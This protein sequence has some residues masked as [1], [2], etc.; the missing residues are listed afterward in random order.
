MYQLVHILSMALCVLFNTFYGNKLGLSKAKS[1]LSTTVS[2]MFLYVLMLVLAWV[3]NGFKNFGQQNMVRTYAFAPL[4]FLLIMVIFKIDFRKVSDMHAVWPMIM[5]GV[6]HFAC[7][8]EGCCGGFTYRDGTAV[9]DVANALTGTN[10]LPQQALESIAALII[11][12]VI[13]FIAWKKKFNLNGRLFYVMIIV[14]GVNRFFWE[15]LRDND[16]IVVFGEFK[17]AYDGVVGLSSLSF[18]CI[19]MIVVGISFL[20]AFHISDKK[21]AKALESAEVAA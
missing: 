1:A 4:V 3:E 2:L 11:G 5:H 6:S 13:F 9:C 20:V 18:H 21:K 8:K 17:S 16:K 14:Y 7:I 19:L 15:F 12:A 10:A